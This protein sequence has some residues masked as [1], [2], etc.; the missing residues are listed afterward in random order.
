MKSLVEQAKI[1][2]ASSAPAFITGEHG[3]GKEH[4]ARLLHDSG[5]RADQPF[6]EVNCA[7]LPRELIESELFGSKKG[8]Y[9]GSVSDRNGLFREAG[10]G[11]IFLDEIGEMPIEVQG[12]L[13]RVLQDKKV[14][15]VGDTVS[16]T[17]GC[18]IIAATNRNVQEAIRDKRLRVDLYYRLAVLPF[19]IPALR[20]RKEDIEA[21]ALHFFDVYS[22]E[23]NK[24]LDIPDSVIDMLR[25]ARWDGNVRELQNSIHRAIIFAQGKEVS[26]S[27]FSLSVALG[28]S[29]TEIAPTLVQR[30]TLNLDAVIRDVCKAALAKH[31]GN[32]LA[33]ADMGIG[34][35]TLYNYLEKYGMRTD[36]SV[37]SINP[38][39]EVPIDSS[40]A[41]I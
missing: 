36:K 40:Q 34:R 20:E 16:Y 5:P 2:A 30:D 32:K 8:S 41:S 13:L 6:V 31:H 7:A 23:E 18:R 12:K 17:V 22:Q 35:Q 27:D 28:E 11:T 4:I 33:A 10:T 3:V 15:P 21:L 39:G 25:N 14:R 19:H 24:E 29:A 26:T 1:A 9:T 37:V 38:C